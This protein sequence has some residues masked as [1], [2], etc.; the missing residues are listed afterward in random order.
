MKEEKAEIKKNNRKVA[1][2]AI[3]LLLL[4]A[5]AGAGNKDNSGSDSTSKEDNSNKPE[6]KVI[7]FSKMKVSDVQ[8][9]CAKNNINCKHTPVYSDT[10]KKDVIV[11]Q[12]EDK[13]TIIHEDDRMTFEYSQGKEPTASQKNAISKAESY[14]DYSAFSKKGLIKQL[15]FEKFD[16]KDAE[17]AVEN[18]DVDWNEQAVKKAE[19]YLDYSSFSKQGLIEQLEFEGFTKAEAQYGADKAYK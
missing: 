18:I 3:V 14:L 12:S 10:V 4:V 19:S 8:K 17:Y 15:E 9:W 6:V 7:D 16:K 13:D 5:A 11:S 2:I 1:I